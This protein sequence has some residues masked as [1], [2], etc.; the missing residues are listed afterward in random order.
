[1]HIFDSV[2]VASPELAEM[3]RLKEA[4]DAPR[5]AAKNEFKYTVLKEL[6]KNLVAY[7]DNLKSIDYQYQE[8]APLFV[9]RITPAKKT[10]AGH[11]CQQA[12]AAF[13]G[14]MWEAW[15][16]R[17]VPV[18]DGPYKFYGLPG[19]IVQVRD[20]HDNYVF[21]LL[22]LD[23]N[24]PPFDA[25]ADTQS[26]LTARQ[27]APVLAK[28]KFIQAKANDDATFLERSPFQLTQTTYQL[29]PAQVLAQARVSL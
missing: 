25:A 14:R 19:L 28:A 1:M 11:E 6:A 15:L 22:C 17:D 21:S 3:P 24:P 9:W 13:G 12:Y 4:L 5:Q 27:L 2:Y 26:P 20:T 16:A 8:K 7:H 29:R 23:T 18:S 10:I